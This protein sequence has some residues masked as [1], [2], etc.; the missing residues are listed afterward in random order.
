[1]VG[2]RVVDE[3][4]FPAVGHEPG[5]T[6]FGQVLTHGGRAGARK[7]G[8]TILVALNGLRLL[9]R[10]EWRPA[11]APVCHDGGHTTVPVADL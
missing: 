4:A 10:A 1:V 9:R 6:Q 8:E 5:Q 7:F 11:T 3:G 2:E